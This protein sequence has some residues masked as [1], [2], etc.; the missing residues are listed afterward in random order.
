ML[1]LDASNSTHNL[2]YQ[3]TYEV[4]LD[5]IFPYIVYVEYIRVTKVRESIRSDD[6]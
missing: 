2:S 4:I 1:C 3:T 6:R 5:P